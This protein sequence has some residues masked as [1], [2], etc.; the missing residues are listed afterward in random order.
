MSGKLKFALVAVLVALSASSALA[1]NNKKALHRA[2]P[3]AAVTDVRGLPIFGP[4]EAERRWM[5]RA[6]ALSNL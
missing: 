4:T 6:S 5:D 2:S 3:R 1:A